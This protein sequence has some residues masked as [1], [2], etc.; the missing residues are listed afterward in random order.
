MKT[1]GKIILGCILAICAIMSACNNGF[2]S[3]RTM[4][5]IVVMTIFGANHI[6]TEKE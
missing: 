3:L 5:W 1:R 2:W 4:F 6:T